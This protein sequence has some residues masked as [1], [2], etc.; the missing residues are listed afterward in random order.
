MAPAA[1][2][3]GEMQC[4][5]A[6]A[7]NHMSLSQLEL[8]R[9]A[10][11]DLSRASPFHAVEFL[12][13]I[14]DGTQTPQEPL[15]GAQGLPSACHL[16]CFCSQEYLHA[17]SLCFRTETQLHNSEVG[18]GNGIGPSSPG[19]S[20]G[21][22]PAST[23]PGSGTGQE[24][25]ALS[26]GAPSPG[27]ALLEYRNPQGRFEEI[28]A[29]PQAHAENS[30]GQAQG[31]RQGERDRKGEKEALEAELLCAEAEFD[32][33]LHLL[34]TRQ[35][36]GN[37]E[38]EVRHQTE[39][40]G[41]SA[42]SS[43]AQGL[44]SAREAEGAS[45]AG[46]VGGLPISS[47]GM[48][49]PLLGTD[50]D[51]D[52]PA[53]AASGA[54]QVPSPTPHE[55]PEGGHPFGPGQATP[56]APRSLA[57]A[58]TPGHAPGT[59]QGAGS[60]AVGEPR[61][62]GQ[63]ST[64]SASS[65]LAEAKPGDREG[66]EQGWEARG[67]E[68]GDVKAAVKVLSRR[69]LWGLPAERLVGVAA[70]ASAVAREPQTREPQGSEVQGQEQ[71]DTRRVQ[72]QAR[73]GQGQ[74]QARESQGS[75][76]QGQGEQEESQGGMSQGATL[77]SSVPRGADFTGLSEEEERGLLALLRSQ[78]QALQSTQANVR[79]QQALLRRLRAFSAPPGAPALTPTVASSSDDSQTVLGVLHPD[80]GGKGPPGLG[81]QGS[82]EADSVL[83]QCLRKASE[84]C[85]L[86]L[87]SGGGGGSHRVAVSELLSFVDPNSP[88]CR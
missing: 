23:S 44:E 74:G 40:V 18:R 36:S 35:G 6:L 67:L 25:E 73:E 43:A 84:K 62:D 37:P 49:E 71:Q 33:L 51:S 11:R 88:A 69:A 42:V 14:L 1:S 81:E 48:R 24:S 9:A 55:Y 78:P 60:A 27:L 68:A 5:E 64:A 82:P 80:V 17:V 86:E 21:L 54:A 30:P 7:A 39:L 4:L 59:P 72:G 22:I 15:W 75:E 63:G 3:E 13:R 29:A 47:G 53:G 57:P 85:L 76:V 2:G 87:D 56:E 32:L 83:T 41:P 38:R 70:G 34:A 52:S 28:A 8:A 58:T 61:G 16:R 26:G 45:E 31:A 79:W 77:P 19:A 50:A 20:A 12:R 10:L 46:S 65:F 66:S